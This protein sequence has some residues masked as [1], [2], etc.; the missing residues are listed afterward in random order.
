M[1]KKGPRQPYHE[2]DPD[3]IT[4]R[5]EEMTGRIK[6]MIREMPDIGPP[7]RLLSSVMEAI[8]AK[9]VPFRIRAY[10]WA[11]TPRSITLTPL[12]AIPAMALLAILA[13][14]GVYLHGPGGLNP[15]FHQSNGLIPVVFTLNMPEAR[16]VHVIGSFNNWAPQPCELHKDNGRTR[17]TLTLRLA[18]GRYEYAF[19]VDGKVMPDPSAEFYQDDGF[20]NQN[21]VLALEKKDEAI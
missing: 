11:R 5:S 18:P 16:T 21:T 17:W 9:K 6:I 10:R 1:E 20:G 13:F 19:L 4:C 15:V 2:T 7:D 3:A 12:H 8:K 14:S